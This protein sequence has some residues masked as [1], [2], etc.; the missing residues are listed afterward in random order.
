MLETPV[1]GILHVWLA[2]GQ[3]YCIIMSGDHGGDARSIVNVNMVQ[4]AP[5]DGCASRLF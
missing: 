5:V 2:T 3:R 1:V 4:E